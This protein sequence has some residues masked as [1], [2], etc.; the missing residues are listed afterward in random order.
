VGFAREVLGCVDF[1]FFWC[2]NYMLRIKQR[3]VIKHKKSYEIIMTETQNL[4]PIHAYKI[5]YADAPEDLYVGSTKERLSQRMSL[6]RHFARSDRNSRIYQTMREKGENNFQY[7][8]LGTCMVRSMDEQRMYEQTWMDRL[9]PTL[10]S[11][12]AYISKEQARLNGIASA[13]RWGNANIEKKKEY[14][15]RYAKSY[16]SVLVECEYCDKSVCRGAYQ[17]HLRAKRHKAN[18]KRMFKEV[19][20]MDITDTDVPDF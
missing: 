14:G 11:Q 5:W 1:Q 8:L 4:Y 6:H 9:N 19:F 2:R 15:K 12:K 7:R 16:Q 13:K 20:G 17:M 10:N 3:I 18:Y